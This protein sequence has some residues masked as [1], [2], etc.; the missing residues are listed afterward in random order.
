MTIAQMGSVRTVVCLLILTSS[1]FGCGGGDGNN[2]NG[3]TPPPTPP[4]QPAP[5]PQLS[6]NNAVKFLNRATFGASPAQI[7]QV[8]QQGREAWFTEQ[9]AQP[10]SLLLPQVE[11]DTRNQEPGQF[12]MASSSFAFWHNAISAE[13]Q[14]RQRMAFALSEIL[15]VSNATND[16]LA[17]YPQAIASYQDILINHAFGNYRQLLQQVTYSPTMGFYLTYL[18][19][20]KGDD[21]T[22]RKPDENYARE[23]LQLFTL[24]VT[25]LNMDG[26]ARLNAEGQPQETYGS[27][28]IEGLARVFTGLNLDETKLEESPV[29]AFTS[30]MA[31]FPED[32]SN[33]EKRFLGAVIPE[34]TQVDDSITQALDIIFAHPNLAPFISKQLIQ[35]LVTSNPSPDYINTVAQAFNNGSYQ[36][37]S[38]QQVGTGQRGDLSATLAAILF[39]TESTNLAASTGGKLR[40]PIIRFTHWARAFNATNIEPEYLFKLWNTSLATALAQHPYR[41]PSVF[42]FFRPGYKAPGSESAAQGLVA[43]ELQITNATS[44]PGYINFMTYFVFNQQ[45]LIDVPAMSETFE[46]IGVPLQAELAPSRFTTS[47]NT[48]LALANTPSAL[49]SHLNNLLTG[50]AVSAEKQ[51]EIVELLTDTE[52]EAVRV[53]LA[54]VLIMTSVDY[55]IQR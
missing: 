31:S 20:L 11:K 52:S 5:D 25:L 50:G 33:K 53:P 27:S 44:I 34:N 7:T 43:P 41:S 32:H 8:Q 17:D 48:E 47:Y 28:D 18:G 23:L 21:E 2:T 35:R 15:V 42:N 55:L 40:E 37:P 29:A 12:T 39:D 16:E 24:G 26:S 22:G 13:D 4:V 9:I 46:E 38:G 10:A 1:L 51:A 3:V 49:V 14:L 19:N 45:R 36:L 6:Y 30:P 54:I